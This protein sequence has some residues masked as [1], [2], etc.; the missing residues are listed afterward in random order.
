MSQYSASIIA[1]MVF[2]AIAQISSILC[3]SSINMLCIT[4]AEYKDFICHLAFISSI[5]A[6]K[7]CMPHSDSC[8][9]SGFLIIKI[10][11]PLQIY[12]LCVIAQNVFDADLSFG[13]HDVEPQ[14]AVVCLCEAFCM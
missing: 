1:F 12:T 8:G 7:A 11:G 10:Q 13:F 4:K 2:F 5:I 14:Q 6:R 9:F 3:C